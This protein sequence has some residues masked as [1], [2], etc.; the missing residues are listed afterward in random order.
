MLGFFFSSFNP[1][2][3][4]LAT[5]PFLL[6]R[7]RVALLLAS[8]VAALP[9]ARVS[10]ARAEQVR[11]VIDTEVAHT[12]ALLAQPLLPA[13]GDATERLTLHVL[14]N[15]QVN[16]FVSAGTHVVVFS[17][18][19]RASENAE[20]LQAVLAHEF[21]HVLADHYALTVSERERAQRVA[22]LLM[23]ASLPLAAVSGEA[24][25]AAAIGLPQ[26]VINL[27]LAEQRARETVADNSALLILERASLTPRGMVTFLQ[28][29]GGERAAGYAKYLQTHPATSARV[30]FLEERVARSPFLS[31]SPDAAKRLAFARLKAKLDAYALPP[32]LVLNK[33]AREKFSHNSNDNGNGNADRALAAGLAR[34]IAF[35][36][37]QDTKRALREVASLLRRKPADP[38]FFEL[39]GDILRADAFGEPFEGERRA[40]AAYRKALTLLSAQRARND[41]FGID[42]P[43]RLSLFDSLLATDALEEAA[44]VMEEGLA[45]SPRSILARRKLARLYDRQGRHAERALVW[46]EALWLGGERNKAYC[47]A[48][49]AIRQLP[50][51]SPQRL[52]AEDLTLQL[53]THK[54]RGER[55]ACS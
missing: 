16:A 24:A 39:K 49:E 40:Q 3:L 47:N 9:L 20:E 12:L 1:L 7:L 35:H 34:A 45:K 19:I 15:K 51:D 11:V 50:P 30:A 25:I 10:Q 18:L 44:A 53:R 37:Q 41:S 33:Y 42:L 27:T 14:W 8:L 21:G 38:F 32:A 4:L 28:K 55:F 43:V 31:N 6:R 2:S 22:L 13:L 17:G 52:R 23:F 46:A 29:L 36:R 26:A 48:Q 54:K 5:V